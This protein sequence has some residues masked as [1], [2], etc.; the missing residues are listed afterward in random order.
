[1]S[2]GGPIAIVSAPS[3]FFKLK[4]LFL[5]KSFIINLIFFFETGDEC[6]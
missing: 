6:A 5:F 4:V 3:V 1:M 2:K